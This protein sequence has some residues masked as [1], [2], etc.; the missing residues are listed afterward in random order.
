M[1]QALRDE[2]LTRNPLSNISTIKK[3]KSQKIFLTIDELRKLVKT[4][5]TNSALK[6]AFIFSCLTGLRYS[7][8][9]KLRWSEVQENKGTYSIIFTQKKTQELN[10]LPLPEQAL[11][12]M[13][14]RSL[15]D[16]VVF[17]IPKDVSGNISRTLRV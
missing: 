11:T 14:E 8:I 6:R 13:G 1:H 15:C 7:D 16:A 5:C 4:D 3:E 2:V 17:P 12:Y 10:Y 9:S